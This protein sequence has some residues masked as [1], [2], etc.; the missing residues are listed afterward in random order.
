MVLFDFR[1]DDRE[2]AIARWRTVG[3]PVMGGRSVGSLVVDGEA[4]SF[5]GVLSLAGGGGFA[6][7]RASWAPLDLSDANGLEIAVHGD[8]R[9]Y[10]LNL[11]DD[12]GFDTVLHRVEFVAPPSWTVLRFP[13]SEFRP[14]YRGRPLNGP[15]LRT[16]RV[17]GIGLMIADRVEG[18]FRM[19]IARIVTF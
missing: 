18:P 8:G 10:R 4:A 17:C 5:R 16:E 3:D 2:A 15:R 12:P 13:F 7:V 1:G 14:T 6:S 19:E 11:R 9:I